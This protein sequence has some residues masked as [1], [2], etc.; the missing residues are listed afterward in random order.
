MNTPAFSIV[1]TDQTAIEADMLIAFMRSAGLHPLDLNMWSH[2]SLGG[3]DVSFYIKVPTG[4]L[5]EAQDLLKGY[6]FS[7]QK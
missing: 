7:N 1:R 3:A 2:Y 6:E 4:E 5:S